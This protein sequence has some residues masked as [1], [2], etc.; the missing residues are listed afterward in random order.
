M[1]TFVVLIITII[2]CISHVVFGHFKYLSAHNYK[3]C[4]EPTSVKVAVCAGPVPVREPVLHVISIGRLPGCGWTTERR[5]A[6]HFSTHQICG[7]IEW[8]R[9]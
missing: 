4:L 1:F 8:L 5:A 6:W 9:V 7:E 3:V 2:V